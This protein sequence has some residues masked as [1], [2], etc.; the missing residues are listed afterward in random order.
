KSDTYY[1]IL[2]A[3]NGT[4]V[5]VS[6]NNI[7]AFTYTFGARVIDG[8]TYGLNKGMVGAGSNNAKGSWDNFMVQTLQSPNTL[9]LLEDFNDGVANVFNGAAAGAPWTAS[10]G[11]YSGAPLLGKT[12]VQTIKL[13]PAR[14]QTSSTVDLKAT[15]R[16]DGTGGLVFDASTAAQFKYVALD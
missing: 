1:N 8:K 7:K 6:V 10:G 9:D 13:G 12:S 5:T 16:T 15:L 3:V 11:R 4:A 14:L 2:V